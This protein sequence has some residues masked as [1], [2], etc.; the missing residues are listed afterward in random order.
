MYLYVKAFFDRLFA[1]L[2]LIFLSPF[3]IVV[4]IFLY[5]FNGPPIFFFQIRPGY[6]QKLFPLIKFRTMS[7]HFDSSGSLLPDGQ[8]LTRIGSFLR[9]SSIDELPS[10]FNILRGEL[11][12]IGPRPLLPE[13][14]SLYSTVQIRRHDVMPGLTGLAQVNGRNA[15]SW[16]EKFRLDVWYVDHQSFWL[17][18]RILFLTIWKV[19]I[20]DG[21]FTNGEASTRRFTGNSSC[22]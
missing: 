7:N 22:Q 17:D 4:S 13:Y 10:L 20:R 9:L 14:L 18:L 5:F 8:R 21:V 16:E 1:L 15:I 3:L 2:L 12:F 11:S 19:V 6:Q